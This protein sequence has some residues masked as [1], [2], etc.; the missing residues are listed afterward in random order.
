MKTQ[1]FLAGSLA[2]ALSA[3]G[4]A[5]AHDT[6][7]SHGG[8]G[9]IRAET[10]HV[11]VGSPLVNGGV[12]APHTARVRVWLGEGAGR[13]VTE[14]TNDLTLADSAGRRIMRWVTKGYQVSP[15]GD[16]VRYELR[17]TYDAVTLAPLG[18]ARTATNGA[19]ASIRIEGRRVH[20]WR[21]MPND[22]TTIV[23]DH[24]IDRPGFFAGAS[25][26]VPLAVG[27]KPGVIISAPVW[28]PTMT[29]AEQRVF[30][31]RGRKTVD[32][33]G[34]MVESWQVDEHRLSDRALL[35]T[36][37]LT[38]SSPYMVYGEVPM[39]NGQVRRMTEVAIPRQ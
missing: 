6:H 37:Y 19:N 17:Q 27:M 39:A 7:A 31:V 1:L 12:Y 29:K 20:G 23:V 16:T 11:E 14:W 18:Y 33:E 10:L 8:G 15:T 13:M 21:R 36:W 32:V 34:T 22:T 38:D 28:S 26:L 9:A 25:D 4:R 3:D 2:F 30:T 24:E 5:Q 35:A